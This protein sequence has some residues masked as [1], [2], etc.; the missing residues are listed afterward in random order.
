[1]KNIVYWCPAAAQTC[2]LC[3]TPRKRSEIRDGKIIAVISST[4]G[5]LAL[6]RAAK[7][8]AC[9][10]YVVRRKDY[11]SREAFDAARC[12]TTLSEAATPTWSCWPG[13]SISVLGPPCR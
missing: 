12:W 2:R 10:A 9:P 3:W 8:P 11:D 5:A 4:P 6:E 1:M 7:G 13:F